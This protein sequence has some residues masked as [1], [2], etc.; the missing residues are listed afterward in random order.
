MLIAQVQGLKLFLE[1]KSLTAFHNRNKDGSYLV[2]INTPLESA[3]SV[4]EVIL[5]QTYHRKSGQ[6][7]EQ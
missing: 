2:R 1:I 5:I 3:M 4:I 6:L 7:W